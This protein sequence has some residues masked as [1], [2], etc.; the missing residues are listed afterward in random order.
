MN[1]YQPDELLDLWFASDAWEQITVDAIDGCVDSM[2]LM[3]RVNDQLA[4]LIFHLNNESNSEK[5]A[6]ELRFF[7]KLCDDFDVA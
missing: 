4:S 5:I 2:D 1:E 6:Y 7:A 3:E